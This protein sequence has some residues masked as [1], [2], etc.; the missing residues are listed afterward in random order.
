MAGQARRFAL[1]PLRAGTTSDVKAT[2][3]STAGTAA[4]RVVAVLVVAVLVVVF[5]AGACSEKQK[6][7]Y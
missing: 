3:T 1:R 7:V 2:R 6:I 5:D 4:P